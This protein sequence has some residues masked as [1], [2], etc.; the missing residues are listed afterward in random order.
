MFSWCVKKRLRS[1]GV[2]L[3]HKVTSVGF[4]ITPYRM[5]VMQGFQS[6]SARSEINFRLSVYEG[7]GRV[8]GVLMTSVCV[9]CLVPLDNPF[10]IGKDISPGE[11]VLQSKKDYQ[12]NRTHPRHT[13]KC[14]CTSDTSYQLCLVERSLKLLPNSSQRE[15]SSCAHL[16]AMS[17]S[18]QSQSHA[19]PFGLFSR[20]TSL[21]FF[22]H[23]PRL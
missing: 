14:R 7:D 15:F 8:T 3:F 2:I 11:C 19:H 1:E 17:K 6:V 20:L 18:F 23:S 12:G 22:T 21:R 9:R 5:M 4:G 13:Q 16:H 10:W